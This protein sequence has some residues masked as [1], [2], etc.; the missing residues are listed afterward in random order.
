MNKI[1]DHYVVTTRRVATTFATIF[2]FAILFSFPTFSFAQTFPP[3]KKLLRGMSNLVTGGVEV[4]KYMVIEAMHAKPEYKASL[5][6]VFYGPVKGAIHGAERI[7]SGAYDVLTF[8][9]NYPDHWGSF[10]EP[11]Y[12]TFEETE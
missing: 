11:D 3:I 10:V 1:N 7:L 6:G 2:L 5:R 12:F 8:P 4:P 9:I